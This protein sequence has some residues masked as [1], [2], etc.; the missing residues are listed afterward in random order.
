[1]ARKKKHEGHVNHER[2]LVSWADFMTLLF[3]LFT[4]L[5]AIS[6]ADPKKAGA[7]AES[8]RAAFK[9]D[10]L[11]APKPSYGSGSTHKAGE[12]APRN[13][14]DDAPMS[15]QGNKPQMV[16]PT[17]TREAKMLQSTLARLQALVPTLPLHA[18]I[19]VKQ[20]KNS[21]VISLKDKAFFNRGSA[22]LLP[23][24]LPVL[25]KLA[26]LLLESGMYLRVEGHTDN[27]PTHSKHFVS[28]WDLSAARAVSVVQYFADEYAYP[29]ETMAVAGYASGR[30][31]TSNDTDE[32]RQSN[33]RVDI[34]LLAAPEGQGLHGVPG[35]PHHG[36]LSPHEPPSPAHQGPANKK[37]PHAP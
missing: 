16:D 1:M 14:A 35:Q 22:K 32:G 26:T 33:R 29:P 28:N 5:Y 36:A 30:P 17:A 20:T 2:W 12:T 4:S 3:A 11:T 9:L 23:P 21:I 19:T 31:V 18:D 6:T 25:D 27:R 34:V 10:V 7:M 8:T 24:A 37:G 13:P 15:E